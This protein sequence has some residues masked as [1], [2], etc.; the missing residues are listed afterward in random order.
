MFSER[1]NGS[2]DGHS[3]TPCGKSNFCIAHGGAISTIAKRIS[4]ELEINTLG[5]NGEVSDAPIEEK[6]E[7]RDILGFG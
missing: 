4:N 1:C 6:M 2:I 5:R 7:S 3:A